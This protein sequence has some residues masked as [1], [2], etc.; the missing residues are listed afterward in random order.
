MFRPVRG[1]GCGI[2][3]ILTMLIGAATTPAGWSIPPGAG[4]GNTNDASHIYTNPANWA[5]GVI[6]DSF[7]GA[8]LTGSLTLYFH[9]DRTTGPQGLNTSHDGG[10]LLYLRGGGT[11]NGTAPADHTLTLVG[12][13]IHEPPSGQSLMIGS[14]DADHGLDLNLGGENRTFFCGG[15][16]NVDNRAS[17]GGITKEGYDYL[18]LRGQNPYT[19]PT[20]INQGPLELLDGATAANSAL[21]HI[22]DWG[23]LRLRVR[24]GV[25]Q[26]GDDVPVR[27][28]GHARFTV[29]DWGVN[30][31]GADERIGSIDVESG[32]PVV[33][34]TGVA[35]GGETYRL[36]ADI[37]NRENRS[38]VYFFDYISGSS[39]GTGGKILFTTPPQTVGG[40]GL[41]GTN[42]A[43]IPFAMSNLDVTNPQ[44]FVTYSATDGIRALQTSEYATS[45]ALANEDDNVWPFNELVTSDKT[46][47]SLRGAV[48]VA[49][50]ATLTIASGLV[51][52]SVNGPGVL[53]FG[54]REGV[55]FCHGYALNIPITAVVAGTDGVT[56]IGGVGYPFDRVTFGANNTYT[57]T[58]T[59]AFGTLETRSLSA[60][61]DD[62]EVVLHLQT[63]LQVGWDVGPGHTE[64]IGSLCGSGTARLTQNSVSGFSV[65]TLIIGPGGGEP[66][67]VTLAGGSISPGLPLGTLTVGIPSLMDPLVV[68][69]GDLMID[70]AGNLPGRDSNDVLAVSGDL[71]LNGGTL[72]LQALSKLHPPT[73]RNPGTPQQTLVQW[74][75]DQTRT[76]VTARSVTGTFSHVPAAVPE[77]PVLVGPGANWGQ[78]HLGFGVF[79]VDD[80]PNCG[81]MTYNAD[82]VVVDLFQAADGDTNA[83]RYLESH[84]VQAI[85]AANKYLT[86]QPADWVEGNFNAHDPEGVGR[87]VCDSK[88]IQLILATGLWPPSDPP[89]PYAEPP[90][91]KPAGGEAELILAPSDQDL[92]N[93]KIDTHGLPLTSYVIHSPD[94]IFTGEEAA[95]LGMFRQDDDFTIGGAGFG[96]LLAGVHD[97]GDV[98]GPAADGL[99]HLRLTYTVQGV[100]GTF[101]GNLSV[102]PEPGT[103]AMLTGGIVG[104]L[105]AIRRRARWR[106]G[107]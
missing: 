16:V 97:L 30:D 94:G 18:R 40:D 51:A 52:G 79:L 19:G 2:V 74:S 64:R 80:G 103:M 81:G 68:D 87:E 21:F 84:D 7:L 49:S 25:N 1:F 45:V 106:Q 91:G 95:N 15:N 29:G 24:P 104:L 14:G 69:S 36:S 88:D 70:L 43:I 100:P 71:T 5:G 61:P 3:A 59:V 12:D 41:S 17:N 58:T 67:K 92:L 9:E 76:I 35:G 34:L 27:L 54:D 63:T 37:L 102:V 11:F 89:V 4:S 60:I 62:G 32:R 66:G 85:L 57:G 93:L 48:T 28:N 53:D 107:R 72:H 31:E 56:I 38:G 44:T 33:K 86:G 50:D 26:L 42:H 6:D 96:V 39:L 8:P 47:N 20:V 75:G 73:V 105:L 10:G 23:E 82:S 101:V 90:G 13:V 65:D 98:V 99:Q 55:V 46:I 22:N 77:V 78:G 83:D